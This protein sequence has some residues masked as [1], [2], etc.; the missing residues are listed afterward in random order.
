MFRAER[1]TLD[2]PLAERRRM[3]DPAGEGVPYAEIAHRPWPLR[4]ADATVSADAVFEAS[5]LPTRSA[6]PGPGVPTDSG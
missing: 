2:H 1:A 5:G 6:S 4:P 3:Y